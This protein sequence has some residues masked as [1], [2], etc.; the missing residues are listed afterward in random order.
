MDP[1]RSSVPRNASNDVVFVTGV[2]RDTNPRLPKTTSITACCIARVSVRERF[3]SV[4]VRM[5]VITTKSVRC[6]EA[7]LTVMT[8]EIF[9]LRIRNKI[10]QFVGQLAFLYKLGW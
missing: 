5:S 9:Q 10:V 6:I 7:M 8:S 2:A 4:V 1:Q 3:L